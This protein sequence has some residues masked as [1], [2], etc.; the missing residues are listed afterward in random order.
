M[1]IEGFRNYELLHEISVVDSNQNPEPCDLLRDHYGS[2]MAGVC[3]GAAP[4]RNV[5][6]IVF[7][8]LRRNYVAF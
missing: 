1:G 4:N 7:A 6:P 5:F 2:K 3:S 8:L